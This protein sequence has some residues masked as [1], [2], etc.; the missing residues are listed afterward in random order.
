MW[1]VK[2][3]GS[4]ALSPELPRWL[5]ALAATDA[6]IVPGGGPFADGVRVAHKHWGFDEQTAHDMA[7]LAMHQYGRMLAGLEPRLR[8]VRGLAELTAPSPGARIWLPL[9]DEL[10]AQGIPATWNISSDS[11]AGWLAGRVGADKLLLVK[12]VKTEA[13]ATVS[14]ESLAESGIVDSEFVRYGISDSFA[15]WLCGP[16]QHPFLARRL[17]RPESGFLR[18]LR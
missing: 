6:L 3:G 11:L 15:S 1:V 8:V 12:A 13:G 5:D 9:P 2:L 14:V 18:V 16:D 17:E 4:L 7:I 10:N